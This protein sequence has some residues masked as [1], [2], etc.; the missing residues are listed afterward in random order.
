MAQAGTA[1]RRWPPMISMGAALVMIFMVFPNPL[2]VP[3]NDPTASA[4]YAPVPGR[5]ESA[6]NANFGETGLASS[7][8]IG[9]GGEGFGFLPGGP[10]EK[11]P[12]QFQARA[13]PCVGTPPRQTEDPL[14]PP[15]VGY[16]DGK[17]TASYRGVTK[18]EIKVIFYNDLDV[19]G[20]MNAQ[21]RPSEEKP[22]HT[23]SVN[24]QDTYLVRTIK[25]QLRYFRLHFQTYGR[26][27]SVKAVKSQGGL[28]SPCGQR[29]GEAIILA[30][31]NPPP[32]AVVHFGDGGECFLQQAAE[33]YGVFGLGLNADVPRSVFDSGKGLVWSF[34]P[35][36][37]TEASLAASFICNSL[38]RDERGRTGRQKANLS[39]DPD[40]RAKTRKFGL[41]YPLPTVGS[42]SRGPQT[43]RLAKLLMEYTQRDCGMKWDGEQHL[44]KTFPENGGGSREAPTIMNEFKGADVTTVICYCVPVPNELSVNKMQNAAT[45]LDYYPE[46]YWDQG[47]R[48]FRQAWN[49]RY[50]DQSGKQVRFGINPQHWANK[51]LQEQ[52]HYKAYLEQEPGTI[53][54]TRFNFDIYHLFLNLFQ[55]IQGAGSELTPETM[56]KGMFTFHYQN[57]DDPYVPTGGYG[58]YG[59]PKAVSDYTW[60]DTAHAWVW[61]QEGTPPGGKAGEG[62]LRAAL[63]GR[64]FYAGEFPF[65][66]Q[67]LVDTQS[68]SEPCVADD[69]TVDPNAPS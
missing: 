68:G 18:D 30:N 49:Q 35:D 52:F 64:R 25:A 15:C 67:W 65:G 43:E 66:D 56:R 20:D 27:V 17:T 42:D 47:S 46:W 62:C 37:E 33:D 40:I 3:N 13:F 55:G 34:F 63:G 45:T 57:Q 59:H 5:Q 58:S 24:G 4:E 21:Y 12:P 69:T 39:S 7:G 61:D 48:M 2:R 54:N 28:G 16:F 10:Q 53:P 1:A 6:E 23:A 32:F 9:A 41:I 29:R 31:E 8:G 50:S 14:S 36:Q 26:R 38:Y 60:I 22:D 44:V 19:E 51:R 11:P